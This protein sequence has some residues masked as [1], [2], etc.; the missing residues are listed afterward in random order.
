MNEN[1]AQQHDLNP[2]DM[3]KWHMECGVDETISTT[4]VNHFEIQ[5]KIKQNQPVKPN[6]FN[7]NPV[8]K[9]A[10][11][12]ALLASNKDLIKAATKTAA[13]CQNLEEL[14]QAILSYDGCS[15]KNTATNTVFSDGNE[16]SDIIVIGEAPGDMED[17][18]GKPFIGETGQ[19]L[20]KM[21]AAIG[22]NRTD[23]FYI[24]NILPWRPPGNRKPTDNE[25]ELCLPFIIRHIELFKPKLIITV[26]GVSANYLLKERIGIT[27]L[28]GSWKEYDLSGDKIPLMPLLHPAY[29]IR[30]PHYKKQ[31]WHDLLSI[32]ERLSS[33]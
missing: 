32:K 22:L 4:E 7:A 1:T 18:S 21:F 33:L 30:Q 31:T 23:D 27:K 12:P 19:L 28:R 13:D 20:D 16:N 3:L 17:K 2:V 10:E 24:T 15:L 25:C 26:G 14:K 11:S 29:L 9:S 5:N 6:I 8:H